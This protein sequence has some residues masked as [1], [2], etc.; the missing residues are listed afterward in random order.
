M[1]SGFVSYERCDSN[2]S[3]SSRPSLMHSVTWTEMEFHEK[4]NRGKRRYTLNSNRLTLRSMDEDD[5]GNDSIQSHGP[6]IK[7]QEHMV[8]DLKKENFD[9]KLRLYMEQKQN[10]TSS[11]KL[12]EYEQQISQLLDKLEESS[13]ISKA[14]EVELKETR[15]R[16]KTLVTKQKRLETKC[17]E[18]NEKIHNLSAD[19]TKMQSLSMQDLSSI[20]HSTPLRHAQSEFK[21]SPHLEDDVSDEE[22][23]DGEEDCHENSKPLSPVTP[24]I[25]TQSTDSNDGDYIFED[26]AEDESGQR[27]REYNERG[28]V[29]VENVTIHQRNNSSRSYNSQYTP[30]RNFY[31][32]EYPDG[33]PI[34][35]TIPRTT[36]E[37][38]N[39]GVVRPNNSRI[40]IEA[41]IETYS[42]QQTGEK[43]KKKKGLMRIFK[44]CGG[45]KSSNL[46]RNNSVYQKT[47]IRAMPIPEERPPDYRL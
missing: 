45:G 5:F 32:Y 21:L 16:E 34:A 35:T 19:L 14:M 33:R 41:N 36:G 29:N 37:P 44:L 6:T 42:P 46:Q 4:I 7:D 13:R 40:G 8:Q 23:D 39:I 2:Q 30:V 38:D 25:R 27:T 17:V 9:L 47:N 11:G 28:T 43:K 1:D 24:M 15:L 22:D 10:E 31:K 20:K 18:Q 12:E 26:E 3:T